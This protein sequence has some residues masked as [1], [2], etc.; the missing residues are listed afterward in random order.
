W[1]RLLIFHE[2]VHILQLDNIS[3]LPTLINAILGRTAAPNQNMPSFNLEGGA[4]WAES[5]T[6]QRGRIRSALFR[7]TLRAQ[8]LAG[9]LH[10]PSAVIHA[11]LDWPG[12]NVWYMY[13]GHFHAWL[14][15]ARDPHAPARY[16]DAFSDELI[17]FGLNNALRAA[18]GD[19]WVAL[20]R[21]W[22]AHLTATARAEADALRAQGL[23]PVRVLA[24]APFQFANPRFDA[25]G[26][27]LTLDLPGD[28]VRGIYRRPGG[29]RAA[30]GELVFEVEAGNTFDR[31]TTGR[32]VLDQVEQHRGVYQ[33]H[34]LYRFDPGQGPPVRVTRGA[35]I[36][37]PACG[38]RGEWAA[39]VQVVD[40]RTRLVRVD[41]EDGQVDV[42][43]DPGD[44]DQVAYPA[45]APG[46]AVVVATRV[47]QR[48]GRDLIAVDVATG[49]VR[50][51]TADH[52]LELQPRFSP[53]GQWLIYTSDRGGVF[54]L[55][56]LPWP[57][58]GAPRRLTRVLTGALDP[59]VAPDGKT[60]VFSLL[61]ADGYDLAEAPFTPAQAPSPGPPVEPQ[62]KSRAIAAAPRLASRSYDPL[63][64][65]WPVSWSPSFA[66][67]SAEESASQLGLEFSAS[68]SLGQHSFSANVNT[69]PETEALSVGVN[70]ALFRYTP[71]WSV[72]ASHNTRTR[73]GGAFFGNARND[74]RE[75]V[76]SLSGA[77]SLPFARAGRGAS[78]ALRYTYNWLSP[79]ENPDPVHDPLDRGPVLPT[80]LQTASLS[81]SLRY[82][83]VDRYPMAVSNSEGRGFGVTV[84]VR[85]PT[86]GGDVQT[87]EVRFD[88]SEY[89]PV[90][91]RHVIGFRLAGAYGR[92]DS[93]R[94]YLYSLGPPPERNVLLDALDEIQF[95]SSFLRG[96]PAET[97][98]GDRYV[99][100]TLEYRLPL[101][102]AFHGLET[103]PV[104]L[105]RMK[106]AAF[107]D[108]AQAANAPLVLEPDA[109]KRSV[110]AELV[111]EVTVGWRMPIDVRA[112]Y[113]RGVDDDGDHQ[114]YVYVGNWF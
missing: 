113:A 23:S 76:T 103:V 73:A 45:V 90:W 7:G 89:I 79:A 75:R 114:V 95:G 16:H 86:L 88:Y 33:V 77:V 56:A 82:G 80:A 59:Q 49:R 107:T 99:L 47:S 85:H 72:A 24:R 64:T 34:D 71:I 91:A 37:E 29:D 58:G 106:L 51:L 57:G 65:L 67:T 10:D 92:G 61:S 84:A 1:L 8:A 39:A 97:V 41:L 112:G 28:R 53:D 15:K 12:A 63:E 2:Y 98:Q 101:F 54:D 14:A 48:H 25:Q 60:V 66:F 83:D 74:W 5:F 20:Y 3:G 27:L 22:Q 17:P 68:D 21:A 104:F 78:A 105:R 38:P 31:C 81:M 44:L 40:G 42:L 4:V 110:G 108:W 26:D 109:F 94:R 55:Y 36:R 50:R 87:A 46:G 43:Y 13:G 102:D 62:Q 30:R 100:S 35:R 52:A 18:T 69:V 111:S 9:R 96:Y 70:Y 6:S 19:S 11:P 93:G 32:L